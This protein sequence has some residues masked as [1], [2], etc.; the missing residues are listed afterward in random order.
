MTLKTNSAR[1]AKFLVCPDILISKPIY[2]SEIFI[3]VNAFDYPH[4]PWNSDKSQKSLVETLTP[5]TLRL[6]YLTTFTSDKSWDMK[7][8][9][10]KTLV[11]SK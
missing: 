7:V 3:G 10:R 8:T 5:C 9:L 4:E 11:L 1:S 6:K 2:L